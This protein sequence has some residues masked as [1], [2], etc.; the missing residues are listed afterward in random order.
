MGLIGI[1][2][3]LEHNPQNTYYLLAAGLKKEKKVVLE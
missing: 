2:E 3:T 1:L